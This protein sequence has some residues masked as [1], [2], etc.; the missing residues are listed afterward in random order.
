[1]VARLFYLSLESGEFGKRLNYMV[2]RD[3]C[4]KHEKDVIDMWGHLKN[5][6]NEV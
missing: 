3:F 6:L 5:I 1:M 2:V 4:K